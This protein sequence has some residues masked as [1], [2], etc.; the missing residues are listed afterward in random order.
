MFHLFATYDSLRNR[1][2]QA[3]L[4]SHIRFKRNCKGQFVS[5]N[6]FRGQSCVKDV[7]ETDPVMVIVSLFPFS[8][9]P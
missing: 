7:S 6:V 9:H 4:Y 1:L 3:L 8:A 2:S 5:G